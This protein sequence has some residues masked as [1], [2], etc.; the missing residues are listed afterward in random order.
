MKS[1]RSVNV[2]NSIQTL[3]NNHLFEKDSHV[4][5]HFRFVQRMCNNSVHFNGI[6]TPASVTDILSTV[7][8][9]IS[10]SNFTFKI[11]KIEI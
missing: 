6:Q 8:S 11:M 4:L 2:N 9:I 10:V 5:H 3:D 1:N 7:S